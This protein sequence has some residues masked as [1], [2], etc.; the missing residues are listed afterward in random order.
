MPYARH[1]TFSSSSPNSKLCNWL[2]QG[3]INS[4]SGNVL[5]TSYLKAKF[6]I[7]QDTGKKLDPDVVAKGMRRALGPKWWEVVC[8]ANFIL[9]LS[10]GSE[11]VSAKG[12]GDGARCACRRRASGL[13]YSQRHR[14]F[15]PSYH[16]PYCCRSVRSVCLCLKQEIAPY[17]LL[18]KYK[19]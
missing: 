5:P 14:A 10:F 3:I 17:F 6:D 8:P 15:L 9:L 16:P 7:G 4:K 13:L 2:F 19:S 18:R 1:T 11:S 12:A